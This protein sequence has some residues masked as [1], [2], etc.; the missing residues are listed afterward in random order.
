MVLT[1][2]GRVTALEKSAVLY[3]VGRAGIAGYE[4]KDESLTDAVRRIH[5]IHADYAAYLRGCQD[6]AY[7]VIY[8]DPMFRHPVKRRENDMEGFRAVAA[9]DSLTVEILREALRVSRRKVIVKERPFAGISEI[10]SSP[11]SG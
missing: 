2:R 9:Y 10:P 1:G 6:G 5:L 8:F 3:E 4:D 7:D 11:M